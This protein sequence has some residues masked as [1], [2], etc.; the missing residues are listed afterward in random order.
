MYLVCSLAA[1]KDLASI[2]IISSD[3]SFTLDWETIYRD[4]D[5]GIQGADDY[6]HRLP[7]S[8]PEAEDAVAAA[9]P[10]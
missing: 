2:V 5:V 4:D 10:R 9:A 1:A 6:H 3:H 7:S 8:S